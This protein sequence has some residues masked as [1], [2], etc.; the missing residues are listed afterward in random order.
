M[1]KGKE[2]GREKERRRGAKRG[3]GKDPFSAVIDVCL[4]VKGSSSWAT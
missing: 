4:S 2:G 3:R 1:G